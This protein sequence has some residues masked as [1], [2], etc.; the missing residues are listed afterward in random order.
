MG[1]ALLYNLSLRLAKDN[2]FALKMRFVCVRASAHAF[3]AALCVVSC[4]ATRLWRR[5]R[6]WCLR[7]PKR[8]TSRPVRAPDPSLP[9]ATVDA[10]LLHVISGARL[11]MA[12]GHMVLGN[13]DSVLLLPALAFS[14][15]A[16][17]GDK[18]KASSND[19]SRHALLPP[20]LFPFLALALPAL[21]TNWLAMLQAN[22][23]DRDGFGGADRQRA[24]FVAS[25]LVRVCA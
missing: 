15:A 11:L 21:I 23:G 2:R 24:G 9:A 17:A 10:M 19:T 1:A 16:F 3:G 12:L 7:R 5:W 22:R 13:S 6:N 20:C 18:E 25:S 14:A 4:A 8:P